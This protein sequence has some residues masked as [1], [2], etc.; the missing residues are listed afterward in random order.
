MGRT[1]TQVASS[2]QAHTNTTVSNRGKRT[3]KS[4]APS[5]SASLQP[6]IAAAN[7]PGTQQ[8]VASITK[9]V[10]DQLESRKLRQ[11]QH[12]PDL[13]EDEDNHHSGRTRGRQRKRSK[14]KSRRKKR[15]HRSPRGQSIQE[16]GKKHGPQPNQDS[17]PATTSLNNTAVKLFD[18]AFSSNTHVSYRTAINSYNKFHLH[19]TGMSSS[20]PAPVAKVVQYISWLYQNGKSANTIHTYLAGLASQHKMKGFED[21]TQC[22]L[23]KKILKGVQNLSAGPD[24]RLP[25]TPSIL[26]QLISALQHTSPNYYDRKLLQAMFTLSFFGFLRVGEITISGKDSTRNIIQYSNVV[27]DTMH[28][29]P[30]DM[31]LSL[32]F[33]KHHS[34][35]RPVHLKIF[36]QNCK[37]ICPVAAMKSYL[38]VRGCTQGPLFT[39]DGFTP[40]TQTYYSS[41]LRDAVSFIGLD[42]SM[43]KPHSFRIGAASTAFQCQI[44]EE[45]IRLMGRWNSDAVKRYFRIPVFDGMQIHNK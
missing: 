19:L 20:F 33:F 32:R 41:K 26:E 44:P 29:K 16:A 17:S 24:M 7:N 30:A 23:I 45:N 14:S 6:E 5:Q 36:C 8:L 4:S 35:H 10:L 28:N 12:S 27:M 37:S 21:P 11:R 3:R 1:D 38:K 43:Y 34:S 13:S 40:I 18:A 22:F 39:L 31:V 42:S 2:S 9:Q 15:R 25:I